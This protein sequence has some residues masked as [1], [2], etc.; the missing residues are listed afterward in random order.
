MGVWVNRI[1]KVQPTGIT[2]SDFL[3]D[4]S[5]GDWQ[6][7]YYAYAEEPRRRE[8]PRYPL[9]DSFL[10]PA[11]HAGTARPARPGRPRLR[12]RGRLYFIVPRL[13]TPNSHLLR[14]IR[15]HGHHPPH[16]DFAAEKGGYR[17]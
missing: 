4:T 12:A 14:T 7:A 11:S 13:P 6:Y 17:S 9:D 3:G 5:G 1:G 15:E 10:L 2:H 16:L 8:T